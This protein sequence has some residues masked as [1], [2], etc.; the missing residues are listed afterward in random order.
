MSMKNKVME[1]KVNKIKESKTCDDGE[2]IDLNG[3]EWVCDGDSDCVDGADEDKTKIQ[4]CTVTLEECTGDQFKCD[5]G[6]CIN[7]LWKCDHDNDCGDGSDEAKDCKDKYRKCNDTE[8]TCSNAKCISK[9]Y[10]CDG[11]DDCGDNS[12]EVDCGKLIYSPKKIVLKMY[13]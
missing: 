11:E 3:F 8:F 13:F 10:K 4:N 9:N 12:D 1:Q 7:S 2:R 6:R 5:N